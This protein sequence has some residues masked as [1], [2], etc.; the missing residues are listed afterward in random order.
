VGDRAAFEAIRTAI[1]MI[2]TARDLYPSDFAWRDSADPY[3]FD[4]LPGTARVRHSI[5]GGADVDEVVAGWQDELA[6]FRA[7]RE[8]YLLYPGPR[9]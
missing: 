3:W 1:A 9:P 7:V 5:A 4:R 6:E 8:Q 2:V